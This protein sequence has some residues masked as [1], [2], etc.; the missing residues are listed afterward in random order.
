MPM[1]PTMTRSFRA[2]TQARGA[3]ARFENGV[4]IERQEQAA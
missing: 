1:S 4:L 3:G 2:C